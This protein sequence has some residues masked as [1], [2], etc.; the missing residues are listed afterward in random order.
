MGF[1]KEHLKRNIYF[2]DHVTNKLVFLKIVFDNRRALLIFYNPVRQSPV[3]RVYLNIGKVLEQ[4]YDL[5]TEKHDVF[6]ATRSFSQH[7]TKIVVS[8]KGQN[9]FLLK[10]FAYGGSSLVVS[11][12]IN[13]EL[14]KVLI[15]KIELREVIETSTSL[16]T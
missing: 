15:E 16:V 9:H 4:F 13:L 5:L 6:E 7:D 3:Y 2:R 1:S 8:K 10:V 12:P 14:L 11:A